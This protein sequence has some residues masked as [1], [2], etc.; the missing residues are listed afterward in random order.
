MTQTIETHEQYVQ[1]VEQLRARRAALRSEHPEREYVVDQEGYDL[2]EAIAA[3]ERDVLG[4]KE[5]FCINSESRL[6]WYIAKLTEGQSKKARIMAQ[7]AAMCKDIDRELE[8]LR[9]RFA[10][11]AE[12]H[13]RTQLTGRRKSLKTL[14]GTIGLRK[15][16]GRVSFEGDMMTDLP[17]E[18]Y[19]RVV[20]TGVDSAAL[21]RLI[22]VQG[23]SAYLAE[24]GERVDFGGLKVK[25][26]SETLYVKA[27]AEE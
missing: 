1:A 25:A 18:L 23:D 26:E 24:T 21:N 11:Q 3:Y 20:V 8:G 22:K 27:G 14:H 2:G 6:E 5:A 12:A 10:D 16:P 15:T 13:L 17:D 19:D 7:A 4:I 9:Y